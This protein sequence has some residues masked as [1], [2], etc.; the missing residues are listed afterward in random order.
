MEAAGTA[1]GRLESHR[2]VRFG[3]SRD[4]GPAQSNGMDAPTLLIGIDVPKWRCE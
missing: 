4:N 3:P 1:H 2:S